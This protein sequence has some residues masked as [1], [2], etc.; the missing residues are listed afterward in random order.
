VRRV[1]KHE[2]ALVETLEDQLQLPVVR[3]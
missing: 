1:V 3:L 2:L